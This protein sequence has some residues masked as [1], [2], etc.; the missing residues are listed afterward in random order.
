M[1]CFCS[2]VINSE[3]LLCL[4]FSLH[5]SII[6]DSDKIVLLLFWKEIVFDSRG[7]TSFGTFETMRGDLPM[8]FDTVRLLDSK[9]LLLFNSASLPGGGLLFTVAFV[10]FL[11]LSASRDNLRDQSKEWINS[12]ELLNKEGD[13][14][15]ELKFSDNEHSFMMSIFCFIDFSKTFVSFCA[16]PSRLFFWMPTG[17]SCVHKFVAVCVFEQI[18]RRQLRRQ[19]FSWVWF[20]GDV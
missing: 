7:Q 9:L 3:I 5:P 19:R 13:S 10:T 11:G 18:S 17:C 15:L 1:I 2:L 20:F 14:V 8:L 16:R 6:D 4:R 12:V